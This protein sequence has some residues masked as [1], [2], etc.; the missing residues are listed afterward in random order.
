MID[1]IP[2]V[3]TKRMVKGIP[4]MSAKFIEL[5]QVFLNISKLA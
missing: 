2:D 1:V 3:T 5:E 4:V